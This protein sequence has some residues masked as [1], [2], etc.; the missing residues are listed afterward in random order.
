LLYIIIMPIFLDS[1]SNSIP[2]LNLN[3]ILGENIPK[4]LA[5]PVS[6]HYKL[7]GIHVP[8]PSS[9]EIS[10]QHKFTDDKEDIFALLGISDNTAAKMNLE[11]FGPH[12]YINLNKDMRSETL[13]EGDIEGYLSSIGEEA[14]DKISYEDQKL[15]VMGENFD[16]TFPYL[17][18]DNLSLL[19]QRS[20]KRM[21]KTNISLKC[22]STGQLDTA[23]NI[24]AFLNTKQ[25]PRPTKGVSVGG[26]STIKLMPPPMWAIWASD[27]P[28]PIHNPRYFPDFHHCYLV[29]MAIKTS[30]GNSDM[31]NYVSS[32]PSGFVGGPTSPL[33]ITIQLAF[34]EVETTMARAS[35]I[36]ENAK[37]YQLTA[38][39]SN[40][41]KATPS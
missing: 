17:R 12:G 18:P 38:N 28:G 37:S 13:G 35:A 31:V 33:S 39:F 10:S 4:I 19:Y 36:P 41:S 20:P 32:S 11:R 40:F 5:E 1:N 15:I 29:A 27:G 26:I 9:I 21:L 6:K 16:Q 25:L 3:P 22:I 8:Y 34:M 30:G 14:T 7:S 2:Y 24:V 23:K